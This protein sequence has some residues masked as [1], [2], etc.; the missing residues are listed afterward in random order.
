MQKNKP[1]FQNQNIVFR[2]ETDNWAILFDPD[3]GKTYGLD[4]IGI[5]IWDNL[6]GKKTIEEIVEKLKKECTNTIP[7][8]A[9]QEVTDFINNLTSKG[10]AG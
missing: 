4:P 6:D 8:T 7:E 9:L 2:K 1:H 10:L 5:F 3:S